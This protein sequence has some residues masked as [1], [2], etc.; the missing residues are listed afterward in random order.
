MVNDNFISLLNSF[1][2]CCFIWNQLQIHVRATYYRPSII[3]SYPFTLTL[4]DLILINLTFWKKKLFANKCRFNKLQTRKVNDS[5]ILL[6]FKKNNRLKIT[7][8]LHTHDI[9]IETYNVSQ[10]G[11]I[12]PYWVEDGLLFSSTWQ[13]S[14]RMTKTKMTASKRQQMIDRFIIFDT[15]SMQNECLSWTTNQYSPI[16]PRKCPAFNPTLFLN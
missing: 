5:N 16:S 13:E 9:N 8:Y 15:K 3:D 11:N 12:F 14:T 4:T 7:L 1:V 6:L 2:I 10:G